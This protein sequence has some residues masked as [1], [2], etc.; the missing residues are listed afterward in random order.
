MRYAKRAVLY[1]LVHSVEFRLK[2]TLYWQLPLQSLSAQEFVVESVRHTGYGKR[3][4]YYH[5][6]LS[7]LEY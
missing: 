2:M 6:G 7:R 5:D 3:H 4:Q 1:G